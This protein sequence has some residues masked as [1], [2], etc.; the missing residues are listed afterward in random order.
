ME[1]DNRN[2]SVVGLTREELPS[3][4]TTSAGFN[5]LPPELTDLVFRH[6]SEDRDTALA[7]TL[8]SRSWRDLALPHLFSALTV[9]RQAA[10]ENLLTFLNTAPHITR[11]VRALELGQISDEDEDCN[12]QDAPP[13]AVRLD[14]LVALVAKLPA[15]RVLLLRG[16]FF[17]DPPSTNPPI[18]ANPVASP[19]VASSGVLKHLEVHGCFTHSIPDVPLVD[20]LTLIGVLQ[21]LPAESIALRFVNIATSSPSDPRMSRITN[22]PTRLHVRELMLDSAD[23]QPDYDMSSLYDT[24]CQ[25]LAPESLES[26]RCRVGRDTTTS[27]SLMR[28]FGDF[29]HLTAG[30]LLRL[31]LP[32]ALSH[33]VQPL[34]DDPGMRSVTISIRKYADLQY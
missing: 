29:L 8:V 28:S 3:L 6:A 13:P 27:P 16:I 14:S 33:P 1:T 22:P 23:C 25:I 12:S 15:L 2:T 34:E 17:V 18:R 5:T 30:A 26:L 20:L 11:C 7:C 21:A 9:A 4:A 32:F 10:F 24:F 31:D 19:G